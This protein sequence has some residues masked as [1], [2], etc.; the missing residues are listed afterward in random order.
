MN[1]TVNKVLKWVSLLLTYGLLGCSSFSNSSTSQAEESPKVASYQ[2]GY[3]TD[4]ALDQYFEHAR[5]HKQA[6]DTIAES[7][8]GFY[9]LTKG[10]D[11]L[12]ARLALIE[13]AEHTLD[14]QYYIF[15]ND[16]TGQL[17]VWRLLEAADRGVRVRLLLDDIQKRNDDNLALLANHPN[18]EIRLFNPFKNHSVN[19][20]SNLSD[21]ERFNRRMHNKSITADGVTSIVG[22]RNI[23]NEYFSVKSAVEFGDFDLLV[24]GDI[25]NDVSNEFDLYWNYKASAPIEWFSDVKRTITQKDIDSWLDD[26]NVYEEF[27]HGQYDF[28]QLPLYQKLISQELT[29]Y[30]G[31][32]SLIYDNPSKVLGG[33]ELLIN[34]LIPLFKE[35]NSSI[36]IVSPYFVPTQLGTN[37]LV[38]EAKKGKKITIVTN[39][40]AS[41]D[42]FAVHGWYAKYRK[43]L[44]EGGV[45]LWEI[46]SSAKIESNWK[47]KENKGWSLTGS[48]SASLHAKSIIID[49]STFIAGSMNWDPRSAKYNTEM[50]IVFE[51]PEYIEDNKSALRDKLKFNAYQVVVE[52]GKLRWIDNEKNETLTS[53]PDASVWRK[54]GAWTTGILPVEDLL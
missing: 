11:A 35:V 45:E 15:R 13:S 50:A 48:S 1:N 26:S 43:E 47:K 53:E 41:T 44:V 27:S 3:Q 14:L 52:D 46:K 51:A 17:L 4:S 8:S 25:V 7:D 36:T 37:L 28:T 22:G 34:S 6:S 18:I 10:H 39:S 40:L 2:L 38:Q 42:V 54:I 32:A 19:D 30:W 33:N 31:Q 5:Q 23:G 9:P 49:N 20:S 29:L 21:I 12:L 24:Y 16:D